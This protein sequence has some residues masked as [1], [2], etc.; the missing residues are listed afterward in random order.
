M[1]DIGTVMIGVMFKVVLLAIFFGLA[2]NFS[3]LEKTAFNMSMI[4]STL[5]FLVLLPV[6]CFALYFVVRGMQKSLDSVEA[7]GEV[8]GKVKS[9]LT[10]F[11]TKQFGFMITAM[12]VTAPIA[13][14]IG[15][16]H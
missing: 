3:H 4:F 8:V 14:I 10:A 12:A 1:P 2:V 5:A 16:S 9:N 7:R 13:G 11:M 15:F 6:V